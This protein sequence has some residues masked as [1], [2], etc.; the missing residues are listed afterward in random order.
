M[1]TFF[2]IKIHISHIPL[3][4][5]KNDITLNLIKFAHFKP[6]FTQPPKNQ[7]T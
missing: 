3:L 1:H 4:G 5:N 2:K 6:L 7:F